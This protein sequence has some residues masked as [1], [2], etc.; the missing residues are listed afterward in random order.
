MALTRVATDAPEELVQSAKLRLMQEW[1]DHEPT[2]SEIVRAA[3]AILAGES[4]ENVR[5]IAMRPSRK[6][7][8]A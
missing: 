8:T 5:G 6:R 7:I 1:P 4:I 3:L 2:M